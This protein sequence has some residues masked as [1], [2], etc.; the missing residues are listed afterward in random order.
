MGGVNPEDSQDRP[1]EIPRDF[2]DAMVAHCQRESPLECCGILG[3]VAPRVSS[4]YP[5]HNDLVSEDRY[6]AD[7][8]DLIQAHIALR[9]QRADILAI[10]HSHPRSHAEPSRI[11]LVENH[12][13][14][15]P[16]IIVSLIGQ[17]PE[18]RVWRLDVDSFQELPWRI[19]EHEDEIVR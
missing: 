11:D 2:H 18:V 15:C 8:Q 16:R 5:L 7:P 17:T 9:E 6:N 3:G 14:P 12:Y 10:Y 4:I 19:I 13:G 1:L